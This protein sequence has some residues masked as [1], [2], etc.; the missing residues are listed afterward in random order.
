MKV[1]SSTDTSRFEKS[2]AWYV[3]LQKKRTFPE[4]VNSKLY[5]IGRKSIW[6]T[7]KADP[8]RI[9]TALGQFVSTNFIN[10]KGKQAS[11][12]TLI[13]VRGQS[14]NAPLLAL[15]INKE[16]GRLGKP[17]LRGKAMER[18]A[19]KKLAARLRSVAFIKSGWIPARDKLDKLTKDRGGLPP[20]DSGTKVIGQMK[21]YAVPAVESFSPFGEIANNVSTKRDT[22]NSLRKY[23]EPGLQRAFDDE[24]RSMDEYVERKMKASTDK[25]NQE[26]K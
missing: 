7:K 18:A 4:I 5:F 12:R 23:G 21:G 13:A 17:G 26:Q 2:L 3:P 20:N 15:I 8:T 19:R 24:A 14:A 10:K 11:K 25:F 22:K 9:K 16:R 6:F 1:S